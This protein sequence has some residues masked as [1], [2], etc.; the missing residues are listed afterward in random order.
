MGRLST[1]SDGHVRLNESGRIVDDCWWRLE[2]Q[3]EE[4]LLD[5]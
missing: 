2:L 3:C 4:V 5:A 1:V